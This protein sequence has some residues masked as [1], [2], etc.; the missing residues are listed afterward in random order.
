[1][2][3]GKQTATDYLRNRSDKTHLMAIAASIVVLGAVAQKAAT[4]KIDQSNV[5][6]KTPIRY[7]SVFDPFALRRI[8]AMVV[9]DEMAAQTG[10]NA[11]AR[12]SALSRPAIRIP[13]RPALRSPFRPPLVVR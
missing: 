5:N 7:V 2:S 11:A 13:Y 1:M 4:A 8:S 9:R 10:P 12:V 3:T 6:G